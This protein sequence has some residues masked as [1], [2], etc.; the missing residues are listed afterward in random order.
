MSLPY[1]RV[2]I[3]ERDG[4]YSA[5]MPELPGCYGEGETP[6]EAMDDLEKAGRSWVEV[7]LDQGQ[8]IPR[9]YFNHDAAMKVLTRALTTR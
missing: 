4:G 1:I 2:I 3:P 9:A 8:E 6:R 7:A 5:T